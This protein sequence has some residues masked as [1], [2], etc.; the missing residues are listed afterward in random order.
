[1]AGRSESTGDGVR[2]D[3]GFKSGRRRALKTGAF[4]VPTILTLHA[5]PAWAVTDYTETAYRYGVNAGLCKNSNFNPQASPS[6]EAE[7]EFVDCGSTGG[8]NRKRII[9][10]SDNTGQTGTSDF[11]NH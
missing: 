4:L 1:M 9:Y 11:Q 10:D 6:S 3:A 7:Q 2:A 8:P 5:A